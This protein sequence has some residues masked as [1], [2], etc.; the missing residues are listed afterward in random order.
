MIEIIS[1]YLLPVWC[2]G[3]GAFFTASSSF[4]MTRQSALLAANMSNSNSTLYLS[5][6]FSSTSLTFCFCSRMYSLELA[7]PPSPVPAAQ[8]LYSDALY[9]K[10]LKPP[11]GDPLRGTVYNRPLYKGHCLRFQIFTLPIVSIHLQ[12]PRRGQ[13]L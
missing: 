13:P 8:K 6:L 2:A 7:A 12:P 3:P 1:G 11:I 10:I 4:C 9:I 5:K